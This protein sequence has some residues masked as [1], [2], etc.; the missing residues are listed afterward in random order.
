[1]SKLLAQNVVYHNHIQQKQ[2]QLVSKNTAP[3]SNRQWTFGKVL[4][5]QLRAS[6]DGDCLTDC[7]GAQLFSAVE[8]KFQIIDSFSACIPDWR[9]H[10]NLVGYSIKHQVAQRALLIFC[11]YEDAIDS[12][13][14]RSDLALSLALAAVSGNPNMA[15]QSQICILENSIKEATIRALHRWFLQYY[16][17][18]HRDRVPQQIILDFDGSSVPTHGNQEGT[19]YHGY[20][21]TNMYFPLFVYDQDGWLIACL[22]R[23]GTESEDKQIV[24][25]LKRITSELRMKWPKVRIILRADAGVYNPK[26]CNWCEKNNVFY[27][28]R[29]QSPGH[30][31]GGMRVHSDKAAALAHRYFH[32]QFGNE[33]YQNS[34]ISKSKLETSIR[35]LK[36]KKRR[37]EKLAELY[38][39]IVRVFHEFQYQ[40]GMSDNDK[41]RWRC[42]RRILAVCTHTDWGTERTFFV[43][44]IVGGKPE[45]I[46]KQIYNRRGAMELSI[47]DM[48]ELKCTRLSCQTFLANQFRLFLHGIA[49]LFLLRLRRLLPA[50]LSHSIASIQKYFIRLPARITQT[51]REFLL[52]WDSTFSWQNEFFTMLRRLDRQLPLL[53]SPMT[54]LLHGLSYSANIQWDPRN[55]CPAPIDAF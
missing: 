11:G 36:D 35:L 33:R 16:I 13:L 22:L 49:Y 9:K 2:G 19:G 21:E 30:G 6:F 23:R 53:N 28:F 46:I 26:I 17:E 51:T 42:P 37:K 1:L 12:N 5:K 7:G 25:E 31:G 34:K 55:D 50:N 32:D 38:T 10:Q 18:Q 54:S 44:N 24:A 47:R 45:D 41:K 14:K 39:R 20:Y 4:G 3:T 48:K 15:S 8:N 43:T 29:I 52:H 27:I 40:S